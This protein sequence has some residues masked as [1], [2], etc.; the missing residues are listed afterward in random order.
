M[1]ESSDKIQNVL[2]CSPFS[3]RV[4]SSS[5]IE[6]SL[7]FPLFCKH[8]ENYT[9]HYSMTNHKHLTTFDNGVSFCGDFPASLGTVSD[10]PPAVRYNESVAG[11]GTPYLSGLGR[12]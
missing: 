6:A 1:S 12:Y 8:N 11:E 3:N 4:K 10:E 7:S 9:H 5:C 2:D